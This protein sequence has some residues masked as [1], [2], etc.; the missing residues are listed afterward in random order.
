MPPK[1]ARMMGLGAFGA[2]AGMIALLALVIWGTI[3]RPTTGID[4]AHAAV[5][6]ISVTVVI[7]ALA[8]AHVVI[9]RQLLLLGKGDVPREL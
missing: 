8:A 2:V 6:W 1:I 5:T 4:R 3:P 7:L 9:A